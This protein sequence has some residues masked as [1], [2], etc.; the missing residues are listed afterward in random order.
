[1]KQKLYLMVSALAALAL[2]LTAC[3]APAI[4]TGI[5]TITPEGPATIR[6][7]VLPIL[8][9]LPMYV[10]Q[11][12]G[13]F[14][15]N[16]VKV[17]FVPV[18]SAAE[19][20]QLMQAGQVDAMINDL[21]SVMFYNK[22]KPTLSVVRF[23]RTAT[24]DHAEYYLLAGKDSGITNAA[25]LKG[26]EIAISQGTVIEY[27]TDR[28]LKEEGLTKDDIKTVAIPKIADRL[29]ALSDG[30]VKA[31]LI[32]DPAA[33]SAMAGGATVIVS[34]A[35][36]PQYG[37]SL[38]SFNNDFIHAHPQAIKGFLAAWEQA[39]KDINA[40][41]TKW[42]DVLSA[43]KLLSSALIGK[44]VLPDYPLASVPTEAQFKDVNAWAKEKGLVTVDV[45]YT[46]S[47]NA[48]FLP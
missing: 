37:N 47:V 44:Y 19:R 8:D 33:A 6:V 14:E 27:L 15:K 40:D 34:D 28:L 3:S 39:V 26:V 23:A 30:T 32:P 22:E 4:P 16:N 5:P 42:N 1:M 20:D 12:Q 2:V 21:T 36:Y 41:K 38:V 48:I 43:N 45:S 31:A 7:A 25:G 10:A 18:A 46:D 11:A 17:E 35:K 24:A 9:G 29:A 13:Y